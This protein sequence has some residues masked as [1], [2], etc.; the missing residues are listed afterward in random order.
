MDYL[1][2]LG[3]KNVELILKYAKN[4]IESDSSWGMKIFTSGDAFKIDDILITKIKEN[5]I[6]LKNKNSSNEFR[7]DN[8]R[9]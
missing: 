7:I 4:V 5:E 3:S 8:S 2:K 1:K 6:I 9:L